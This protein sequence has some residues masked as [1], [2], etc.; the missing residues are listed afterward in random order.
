M[1]AK[2]LLSELKLRPP[3]QQSVSTPEFFRK[4]RD[5]WQKSVLS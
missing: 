4:Q 3:K 5:F 2:L 1:I